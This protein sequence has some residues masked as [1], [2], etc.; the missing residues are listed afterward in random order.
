MAKLTPEQ[1]A[2]AR[3]R[4]E[5][6]VPMA[7]LARDYG[8]SHIAIR[9]WVVPEKHARIMDGW[10]HLSLHTAD[11]DRLCIEANRRKMPICRLVH[12]LIERGIPRRLPQAAE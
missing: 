3:Q 7:R 6:G 1:I 4:Y 9:Y 12:E 8:V 5:D 10:T 2:E 11:Y